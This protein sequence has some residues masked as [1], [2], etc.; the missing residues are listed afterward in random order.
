MLVSKTGYV[1][2]FDD[3]CWYYK[4]S[5]RFEGGKG[6]YLS[7]ERKMHIGWS[8]KL[9]VM[10]DN[11]KYLVTVSAYGNVGAIDFDKHYWDRFFRAHGN[12]NISSM[13]V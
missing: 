3:K 2:L 10:T 12:N 11:E 9:V 8:A 6:A 1:C 5:V 4:Y 13:A 7:L